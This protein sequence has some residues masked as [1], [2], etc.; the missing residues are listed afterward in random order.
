MMLPGVVLARGQMQFVKE[1]KIFASSEDAY[2]IQDRI[3]SG[4]GITPWSQR[5]RRR[6]GS[7]LPHAFSGD[8][9]S[10]DGSSLTP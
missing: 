10:R 7:Q 1:R 6:P 8:T 2:I 4:A 3:E 5:A 9:L